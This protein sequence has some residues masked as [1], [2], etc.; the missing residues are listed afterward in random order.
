M[1]LNYT[2][3]PVAS[4]KCLRRFGNLWCILNQHTRDDDADLDEW[5]YEVKFEA[6]HNL[7]HKI[8][9]EKNCKTDAKYV[10]FRWFCNIFEQYL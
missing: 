7:L 8:L 1:Y 5:N 6:K 9:Y 10:F 2:S 4:L 3:L